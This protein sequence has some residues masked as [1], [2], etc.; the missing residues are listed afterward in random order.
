LISILRHHKLNIH[1][2]YTG[3]TAAYY[4]NLKENTILT[5]I[6]DNFPNLKENPILTTIDDNFPN[7]KVLYD[8]HFQKSN[9]SQLI[10]TSFGFQEAFIE[11]NIWE[12][13]WANKELISIQQNGLV[14]WLDLQD[15]L[16]IGKVISYN[17]STSKV[18]KFKEIGGIYQQM[19]S[20]VEILRSNIILS[21]DLL[22]KQSKLRKS[23]TKTAQRY[24]QLYRNM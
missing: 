23:T 21:G 10:A 5:T 18:H 13:K 15:I 11:T 1:S 24:L 19:K 22:T 4:S 16:K 7:I 12:Q 9:S 6:D 14:G 3:E 2:G 20:T 8:Q 17:E